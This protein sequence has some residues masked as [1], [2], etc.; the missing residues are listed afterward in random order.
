MRSLL[1]VVAMLSVLLFGIG[2]AHAVFGVADDVKG[3]DLVWPIICAK[4]PGSPNSLNTNWAIAELS[5]IKAAANCSIFDQKSRLLT[6]FEYCW[7]ND[8]VLTD[9]CQSLLSR[10]P[11]TKSLDVDFDGVPD[12]QVTIP[13]GAGTN[14]SYWAGY[15]T[16]T[17]VASNRMC[18]GS[19]P[20]NRF[21]NNM[22]LVD[23]PA[24]FAAGF[25]GTSEENGSGNPPVGV[26][27]IA[28]N[29]GAS[30]FSAYS[31][32]LRY[33]IN[34]NNANSWD[35]WIL[36]LG[37]NQYTGGGANSAR[38]LNGYIC[39]ENEHC[40]S[41]PVGIPWELNIINV[42]PLLPGAPF[43]TPLGCQVPPNAP[44]GGCPGTQSYPKAGFGN[45]VVTENG[46]RDVP[47]VSPFA[48]LG[49]C[50]P[51]TGVGTCSSFYSLL[52]WS[53]Q[54]AE[55]GNAFANFDVVHPLFRTYCSGGVAGSSGVGIDVPCTCAGAGC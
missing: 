2:T 7:T 53:W 34:N 17:Q 4:T 22:Y 14:I 46:S 16:C 20:T 39:D 12:L 51:G 33:Y 49:T 54:R 55:A 48:I 15:V 1:T 9:D 43:F 29:A 42:K 24:G 37:R 47:P 3:Q 23:P 21:M 38:I 8:D 35:W 52:G 6:D 27:A 50:N 28:E 13:D 40:Q 31:V 30:F 44:T 19:T 5:G 18:V 10:F 45:F 25:N 11:I 36:L 32:A 26:S 41:L